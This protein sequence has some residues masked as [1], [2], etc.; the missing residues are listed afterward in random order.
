[1]KSIDDFPYAV[2][3]A[4]LGALGSLVG[5][6]V[7][8]RYGWWQLALA[9]VLRATLGYVAGVW[10]LRD[11]KLP[12]GATMGDF[13]ATMSASPESPKVR[14][15]RFP[16][17]EANKEFNRKHQKQIRGSMALYLG[18]LVVVWILALFT[19]EDTKAALN[20]TLLALLAAHVV[21]IYYLAKMCNVTLTAAQYV[22]FAGAILV[23]SLL[24]VLAYVKAVPGTAGLSW[25]P[26]RSIVLSV[27]IAAVLSVYADFVIASWLQRLIGPIDSDATQ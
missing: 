13:K 2:I 26:S 6:I 24:I 7:F 3:G 18:S 8:Y 17:K 22:S 23:M 11:R 12:I 25:E 14:P 21:R 27:G 4:C 16:F 1:M 20:V 9:P 5:N 10:A 19:L 15:S